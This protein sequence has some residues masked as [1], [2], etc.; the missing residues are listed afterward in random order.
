M[1]W[2]VGQAPGHPALLPSPPP[3]TVT[4]PLWAGGQL[5]GDKQVRR[6]QDFA[7]ERLLG[8]GWLWGPGTA[9]P[10]PVAFLPTL[11]V[12]FRYWLEKLGLPGSLL[13]SHPKSCD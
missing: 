1:P 12:S 13:G 7:S 6:R 9:H 4:Q 2:R 11:T 8:P 5:Q 3:F 10:Y